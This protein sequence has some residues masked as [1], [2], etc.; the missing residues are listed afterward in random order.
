MEI[1]LQPWFLRFSYHDHDAGHRRR[2]GHICS[3]SSRKGGHER[4][5]SYGA[6]C[7]S[8]D[9]R[10]HR[11][12]GFIFNIFRPFVHW[13]N[14][15]QMDT[16]VGRVLEER[17]AS[18][19]LRSRKTKHVIDLALETYLKE[20][21]VNDT[22]KLDPRFKDAAIRNIKTFIFA[23]HDTSSSTICYAHYQLSQ[24]PEALARL[25]QECEE[26]FGPDV[27]KTGDM[28]KEDPYLLNK[29]KYGDAVVR[30]TLRLH[31]PASAI[32]SGS[33]DFFIIDPDTGESY[34]TDGFMLHAH[35]P[36]HLL[37]PKVWQE[38][39]S[40][41]PER[42]LTDQ[43]PPIGADRDAFVAF[44]KGIRN[45]I[46]QEL[47]LLEVRM[48]LAMTVRQFDFHEAFDEVEKL[49]E[50]GSGYPSDLS[51]VQKQFGEKAY[52]IQLGTAKPREDQFISLCQYRCWTVEL[53]V[54]W[55]LSISPQVSTRHTTMEYEPTAD[56]ANVDLAGPGLHGKLEC[57]VTDP[58]KENE[59]TQNPFISY[60][61][62]TETDFKSFVNHHSQLRRRF[63]DF[64]FLQKHLTRE[65]P[66]CAV[67]PLPDKHKMEYVRGD[68]FGPDFTS[69]RAHALNRFLNRLTLHPVLRRAALLA[70]FL[71]SDSWNSTM[72]SRAARGMSAGEA[73]AP[74]VL[75]TWTD[76][77]LNAF[78]KAHKT[79]RRFVDVRE[80]SDK[81][82][83]DLSTVSKSV[84]R[85]A[86]RESD[87]EGDYADLATQFQKLAQLE[88]GVQNE[89]TSFGF[90]IQS[91]SQAWKDLREYTDQ[92][93]LGSLRDMEAYIASVKALLK[94]RE[95]K[96]LD[97]EGLSEYLTK[98]AS[99]RDHL[100]SGPSMGASGFIRAKIEDVR[101]VDHETARKERVRKLELQIERLQNEVE[102]AKKTSEAFDI[103][104]VKE[105]DD[106]ER[107][108]AT[109]FRETLG[110][111][112]DANC[113]YFRSTIDT[114]QKFIDQMEREQRESATS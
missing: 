86:R 83:E 101:G 3:D 20:N 80:R 9:R 99:E 48:V 11:P 114:W 59:G 108:K 58:Q 95:Q 18:R 17:F 64:V 54:L 60:L 75:E 12:S 34:P 72:R 61:V 113:E 14:L 57:R 8:L 104:V 27:T 37:N 111:L 21:N 22:S 107:I 81:L 1:C 10:R 82:D 51:G 78:A 26:I 106:F 33:K 66:Q 71:E 53:T 110:G 96:Q 28:I 5:V 36:G 100:A 35:S 91:N 41:R 93:Y 43:A 44:S 31:S 39:M 46:G 76:S 73:A 32:R 67:P 50:D 70:Q 52:Q 45:C 24:N 79:D 62:T 6:P 55:Y 74:S 103:E 30:E 56:D 42:W 89:L 92:D 69:R 63:T 40:F 85:L 47:A 105:V 97:F 23:G 29:M 13:W 15:R 98:A 7:N 77:F 4:A 2:R 65:Y 88:P 49:R 25:R 87:L 90:S 94:T 19:N 16:Y 68:R 112:A 38:P 102:A 109:E 84:S